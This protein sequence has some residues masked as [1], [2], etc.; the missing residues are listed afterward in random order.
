LGQF[1]GAEA[2]LDRHHMGAK[3]PLRRLNLRRQALGFAQS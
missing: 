1:E 3:L 2:A